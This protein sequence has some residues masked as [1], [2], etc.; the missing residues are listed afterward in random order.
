MPT[1]QTASIA[2]IPINERMPDPGM[3]VLV[4]TKDKRV[5]IL[6]FHKGRPSFENDQKWMDWKGAAQ[7]DIQF[8]DVIAWS[9]LPRPFDGDEILI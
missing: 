3:S 2:W 5:L 4:T 9:E 6:R 8:K 7:S 1:Y